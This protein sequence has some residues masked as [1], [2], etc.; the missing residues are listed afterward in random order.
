ME[1]T[2]LQVRVK[3]NQGLVKTF[4]VPKETTVQDFR[5]AVGCLGKFRQVTFQPDVSREVAN[6]LAGTGNATI[7]EVRRAANG[8]D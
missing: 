7:I 8:K 6:L 1:E 3:F 5:A 2:L 4:I